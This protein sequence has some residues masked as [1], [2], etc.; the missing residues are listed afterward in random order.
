M[1][2]TLDDVKDG[3]EDSFGDGFTGEQGHC[4]VLFA[5][6]SAETKN[7]SHPAAANLEGAM[8]ISA[9]AVFNLQTSD[10]GE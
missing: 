4:G 6:G 5:T 1:A 3:A 7:W 2:L 8:G 10:A 9:K